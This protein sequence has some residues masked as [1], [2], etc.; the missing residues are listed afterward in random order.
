MP[1]GVAVL[2]TPADDSERPEVVLFGEEGHE[3]EAV[4]VQTLHQ[5]PVMV[6]RQEVKEESN[7]NL[8]AGLRTQSSVQ[9]KLKSLDAGE[10]NS[11]K[12]YN[13]VWPIELFFK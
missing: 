11:S 12:N 8:T 3:D 10:C 13:N 2:L 7:S 4:Q 5:D 6:G 9:S 1:V